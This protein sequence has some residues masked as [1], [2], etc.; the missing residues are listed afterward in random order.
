MLTC[1]ATFEL[2][3]ASETTIETTH[4]EA[5]T[6]DELFQKIREHAELANRKG[7]MVDRIAIETERHDEAH[8]L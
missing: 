3:K 6:E 5:S 8:S 7:F 4:F 2:S 1:K